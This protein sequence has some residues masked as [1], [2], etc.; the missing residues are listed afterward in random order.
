MKRQGAIKRGSRAKKK[1]DIT[2]DA[3]FERG[4]LVLL[5]FLINGPLWVVLGLCSMA[6]LYLPINV[7]YRSINVT[8]NVIDGTST[9]ME[10]DSKE[11]FI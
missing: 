7:Y 10:W 11:I 4:A 6:M 9:C 8:C 3:T 5:L 1:Y 2:L